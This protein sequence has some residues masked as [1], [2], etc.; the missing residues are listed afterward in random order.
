MINKKNTTKIYFKTI[1]CHNAGENKTLEENWA[2]NSEEIKFEFTSPGTP[3]QNDV[4][5]WEFTTLYYSMHVMMTHRGLH[6]NVKTVI[7]PECAAT[8]TKLENLC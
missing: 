5:E 3:Q 7:C 4:V 8:A 6:E 1:L 2:K